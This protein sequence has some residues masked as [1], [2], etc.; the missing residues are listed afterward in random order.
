MLAR[1]NPGR[2]CVGLLCNSEWEGAA[3]GKTSR[4]STDKRDGA[5]GMAVRTNKRIFTTESSF[6]LAGANPMRS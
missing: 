5:A 3:C 2:L 4:S 1:L 6:F